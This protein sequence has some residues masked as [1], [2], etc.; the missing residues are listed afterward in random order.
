MLILN[1]NSLDFFYEINLIATIHNILLMVLLSLVENI[2][3]VQFNQNYE[4]VDRYFHDQL[5][6]LGAEICI[7]YFVRDSFLTDEWNYFRTYRTRTMLLW[8]RPSHFLCGGYTHTP[9]RNNP[10]VK[11]TPISGEG[12]DVSDGG[13]SGGSFLASGKSSPRH[14]HNTNKHTP[15]SSRRRNQPLTHAKTAKYKNRQKCRIIATAVQETM[16]SRRC[17][18]MH[19]G[20]G[21]AGPFSSPSSSAYCVR[22]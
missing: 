8:N 6:N 22:D 13:A 9:I 10:R 21:V 19:R 15:R 18:L 2:F 14:Q 7:V 11:F 5:R 3:Y 4:V 12:V 17:R 1:G 16:H 20:S